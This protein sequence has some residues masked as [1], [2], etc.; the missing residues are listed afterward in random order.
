MRDKVQVG[1]LDLE[2]RLPDAHLNS[3]SSFLLKGYRSSMCANP[4]MPG[5]GRMSQQYQF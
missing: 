4:W 5:M 2:L 1:L 3:S